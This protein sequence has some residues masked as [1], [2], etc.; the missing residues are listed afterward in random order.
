MNDIL[1]GTSGYSYEDWRDVLYPAELPKDEFL[2]YY[3]LFFPFTEL[4]F[5]YYAMPTVNGLKGM[6][7][8]TPSSFLFSIKA[9]KSLTHEID[10]NW[11]DAAAQFH[12]AAS[13]LAKADRLAAVLIQ[14]PY[15]F[16]HTP[17]NRTYLAALLSALSPLPLVVEFRNDEWYTPRVYDE[18]DKRSVGSVMVDR[19]DLPGLPPI[20]ERV[21]GGLGYIRFHGRNETNWWSGDNVSRYDYLY[22]DEELQAC[23]PRLRRMAKAGTLLVAFNNHAKGKA[24]KNAKS[25]KAILFPE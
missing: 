16:H 8:R 21:T 7:E 10:A 4:N 9:H 25:L 18:L 6:V 19:P 5:S 2:R 23:A 24:V 13:V 11:K 12:R 20:E 22:S 3:S 15:S 1:I 17:D 14:L